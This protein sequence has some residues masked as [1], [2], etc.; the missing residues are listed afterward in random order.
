MGFAVV[1]P[2]HYYASGHPNMVPELP[3]PMGLIESTDSG[4]TWTVLSRGGQSDFHA[5]TQAGDTVVAFD[6]QL[7]RTTDRRT[8]STAALPGEPRTLAADPNGT[9][10]LATTESGLF[11]SKD[12]GLTWAPIAGA[13]PLLQVAWGDARWVAGVTP[14][15]A[16]M[17][18]TD[19]AQTWR[20]TGATV[21]P[22]QAVSASMT[23]SGFEILVVTENDVLGSADGT[24]F[25]PVSR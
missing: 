18:S 9:T 13:P 15:G 6:G 7:R 21:S 25:A 10:V 3:Q 4:K 5:L 23:K 17:L 16:V 24:K 20:M 12:R 19:G 8:W 22:P 11:S 14:D 1:G 2:G